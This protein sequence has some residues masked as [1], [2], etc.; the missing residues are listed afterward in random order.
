MTSLREVW[1]RD[2]HAVI[3]GIRATLIRL[4]ALCRFMEQSD[5]ING[6]QTSIFVPP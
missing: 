2:R 4:K 3:A 5:D 1:W 6:N